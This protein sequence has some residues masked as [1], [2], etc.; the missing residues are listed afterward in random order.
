MLFNQQQQQKEAVTLEII[1]VFAFYLAGSGRARGREGEE[2]GAAVAGAREKII[3]RRGRRRRKRGLGDVKKTNAS[4]S[5]FLNSQF[6]ADDGKPLNPL[7][8]DLRPFTT[9]APAPS[10]DLAHLKRAA[11]DLV[12]KLPP[13][14]ELPIDLPPLPAFVV[15]AL[16]A[17]LARPAAAAILVVA[18]TLLAFTIASRKGKAVRGSVYVRGAGGETVRRSSR[19]ERARGAARERL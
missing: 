12:G 8:L 18:A 4:P 10:F 14:P 13:L 17:P 3:G 9:M 1:L 11:A 19:Y 2:E 6:A 5:L 7:S 15:E 16:E